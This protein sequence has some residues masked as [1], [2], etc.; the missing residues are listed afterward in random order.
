[1]LLASPP[2]QAIGSAAFHVMSRNCTAG[3]PARR[4]N[5]NPRIGLGLRGSRTSPAAC[6][7]SGVLLRCEHTNC[8]GWGNVSDC[9][10]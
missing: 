8:Q 9:S 4:R 7:R 3:T 2:Q 10:R 1:M 5:K 6:A